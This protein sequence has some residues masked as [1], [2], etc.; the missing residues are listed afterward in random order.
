VPGR[1]YGRPAQHRAAAVVACREIRAAA[2]SL[3]L[4]SCALVPWFRVTLA[5]AAD[6]ALATGQSAVGQVDYVVAHRE[7]TLLD[8]AR[9]H[10]LGFTQLMAA[11]R[12]VDPW[13]PDDGKRIALPNFY[14]LPDARREGI[15]VNLAAQRLFYFPPGG[16]R[17]ETYPIGVGVEGR[18][19]PLGN[20]RIVR[21]E[22]DATWYPPPSIR[23][24]DADLP[25]AVHPGPDNPLGAFA[26]YLGWRG[27]LIHGTNKPDGVGRNASHGCLHLYPEDIARVF[28][29]VP[30]G[31]PVR[32][33]DQELEVAWVDGELYVQVHPNKAQADEIDVSGHFKPAVPPDLTARVAA[34]AG[35][36]VHRVDWN[37]V[38]RAGIERTGLPV[39]VTD[40]SVQGSWSLQ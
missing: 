30:V 8:V 31:T 29:E 18:S 13:L 36:S 40:A 2:R 39:R 12:G 34:A 26:L 35:E 5:P 23:A 19:T 4:L 3:R 27:Y 25:L 38:W 24:E 1:W 7:D 22:A 16:G 6:Y 11:N 37:A 10:G 9:R 14:L 28:Q 17:V 21:K 20:T 32:V 33:I 15:V